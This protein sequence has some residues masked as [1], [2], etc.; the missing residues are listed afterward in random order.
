MCLFPPLWYLTQGSASEG[1]TFGHLKQ[2]ASFSLKAE[3]GRMSTALS[4]D[5]E[6]TDFLELTLMSWLPSC[7]WLLRAQRPEERGA[8]H[9][10]PGAQEMVKGN[11]PE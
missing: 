6:L 11:G 2:E 10:P 4:T 8:W 3:L 5:V 7:T 9:T 1:F